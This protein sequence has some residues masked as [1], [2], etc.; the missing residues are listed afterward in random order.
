MKYTTIA[1]SLFLS[2]LIAGG[3][4][5]APAFAQV[6]FNIHI[7]PPELVYETR[8]VMAPGYVWAPGYWAWHGDNYVWV[9]GRTMAQRTGYRWAPDR[10]EQQSQGYVRHEG[11]WER[12][13]Q[14]A[15]H[16]DNRKMKKEKKS[17]HH[18]GGR[19]D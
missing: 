3:V 6:T 11:R 18:G 15:T 12:E 19:H 7:A 10:W 17:K 16:H 14:Q 9:R 8:P 5:S 4:A 13:P 1:R 2:A